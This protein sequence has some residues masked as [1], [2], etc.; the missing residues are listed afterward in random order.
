MVFNKFTKIKFEN[1][2]VIDKNKIVILMD[3]K[4]I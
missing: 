3:I 4:K 1:Q 2:W